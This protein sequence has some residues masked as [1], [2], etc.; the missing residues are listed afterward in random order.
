M[1]IVRDFTRREFLTD[2]IEMLQDG[3]RYCQENG[4][5]PIPSCVALVAQYQA[6]LEQMGEAP[7]F[8][9]SGRVYE[10][11]ENPMP[12]H[13]RPQ[14][15]ARAANQYGEFQVKYATPKQVRFIA[16]LLESRNLSSLANSVVFDLPR[17]REMVL[18]GKV[19]KRAASD[20]I[21]RLLACP[22]VEQHL[23]ADEKPAVRR[24]A[25]DKQVALIKRLAAERGW[26]DGLTMEQAVTH[27]SHGGWFVRQ[28]IEGQVIEGRDA[29]AAIDFLFGCAKVSRPVAQAEALE[30]GMYRT[31]DGTMYRVYP[32]RADRTRLLAKSLVADGF[33]GW[34]FEYAGMAQRFVTAADRM[35][36]EEA[37]AFG[38]EFGVCCVCAALLTDPESVAK[39]IGPV[40]EGRV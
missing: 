15:G 12:L 27:K 6:E 8:A 11:I 1:A 38:T 33:G 31:Q 4:E 25:S 16:F 37:K 36:L 19:N 5:E 18:A 10:V 3:I 39:G 20:A 7:A 30:V 14:G 22:E 40:C 29:S 34:S 32:A 35:T 9:E 24:P 13:Q 17:L 2:A 28:V 23:E 26:F 21:E